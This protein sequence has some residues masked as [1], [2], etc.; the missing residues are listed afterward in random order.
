VLALGGASWPRTGSDGRWVDR[1]AATPLLPS[2]VGVAVPWSS[3]LAT[4]FAGTPLKDVVLSCGAERSRG[5]IIVT[6]TGLEGGALYALSA[7]LR[8][9]LAAA[10]RARVTVD[11]RPDLSPDALTDRL[12]R[13]RP[14]ESTAGWLRRAGLAPVAVSLLREVTANAIPTDPAALAAL[15]KAVPV[16]VTGMQPIDRA[17]STAGGVRFADFDDAFMLRARPGVFVAGEM[18][19]WDAPTG[20]YLLQ[21][22]FS[23]GVAAATGALAYLKSARDLR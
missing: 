17:I 13:R 11:L 18:L 22:C 10:R 23:T 14:K 16:D 15:T 6:A 9:A 3:E 8:D 12:R 5:D 21:A 7:P 4:R 19:D 2:N 1:L 20:G